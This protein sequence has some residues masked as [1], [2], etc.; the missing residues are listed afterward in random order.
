[1]QADAG[2]MRLPPTGQRMQHHRPAGFA[3][4]QR[5][6]GGIKLHQAVAKEAHATVCPRQRRKNSCVEDE[7]A[8][9]LRAFA[10]RVVEG[11]VIVHP[12]IAPEP[13][14][15][16]GKKLRHVDRK[17]EPCLPILRP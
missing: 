8:V 6:Q 1:M 16:M 15:A 12:Q 2:P 4:P 5:S 11:R 9:H 14:Q 17:I 7:H 10:Q 3:L 13:D